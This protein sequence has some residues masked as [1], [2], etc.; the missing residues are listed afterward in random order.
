MKLRTETAATAG[1][2]IRGFSMLNSKLSDDKRFLD[3]PI[4]PMPKQFADARGSI[5]PLADEEM[6]SAVF[7][8]S[9][10][11]SIRANHYHQTDWHYCYVFSGSIDYYFRPVGNKQPPKH[12]KVKTGEIFFTPPMVEHAMCFPEDTA[13]VCLGRNSRAQEVYE[14]DVVRVD[15]VTS[16]TPPA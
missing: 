11:G 2:S 4:V 9:K 1:S 16:Y 6:K 12:V 5:L 3:D 7:I 13:F 14:A 10:K 8:T 15:V